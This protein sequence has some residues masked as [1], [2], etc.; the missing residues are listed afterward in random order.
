LFREDTFMEPGTMPFQ[1]IGIVSA[2]EIVTRDFS[3]VGGS[4][5]AVS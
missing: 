5:T 3:A 2:T 1:R 4:R